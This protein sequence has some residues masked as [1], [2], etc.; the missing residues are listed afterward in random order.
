MNDLRK[1]KGKASVFDIEKREWEDITFDLGYFHTWGVN[2][3]ECESGVGIFSTAIVE[4]PDGRIITPV[5]DD[6]EF[7]DTAY[8]NS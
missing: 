1:C 6:I 3:Q 7:L 2:Y 8:H 4:L 5:A